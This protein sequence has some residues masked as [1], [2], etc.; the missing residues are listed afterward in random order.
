MDG[1]Q[2][3]TIRR[4]HSTVDRALPW[5]PPRLPPGTWV[6][7]LC[8][9]TGA[10]CCQMQ[11]DGFRSYRTTRGS[12][13]PQPSHSG[14][15][16]ESS[17]SQSPPGT[18]RHSR[19]QNDASLM[20]PGAAERERE[21]LM[22]AQSLCASLI[23]QGKPSYRRGRYKQSKGQWESADEAIIHHLLAVVIPSCLASRPA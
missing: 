4:G 14:R 10:G 13:A 5:L 18:T 3:A 19:R 15:R 8:S 6:I 21:E 2:L 11:P 1:R 23:G 7:P 12:L 16:R 20:S 17:V 22:L 9:I